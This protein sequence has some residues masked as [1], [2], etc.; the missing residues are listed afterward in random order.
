MVVFRVLLLC[1]FAIFPAIFAQIFE[2]AKI[3]IDTSTKIADTD[4]PYICATI[5]LWPPEKCNYNRCPW[6][7]SSALNLNLSHPFLNNAI[8]AF[9]KLRVRV[10][11]S[12]QDQVVYNVGELTSPCHPFKTQKG[13]LFGFSKGCLQMERW[14]ELN[15]FF[16]RTG[17]IVTFGLNALY[18]RHRIHNNKN[19]WGGTWDSSNAR[20]FITYTLSRGYH[21][22]SWEF[23]SVGAEQYG[24]DAIRLNDMLN[25][26][27]ANF[28]PKSAARL[29]APSG[30][31][32]KKWYGDLLK[33]SGPKAVDIL[34]YHLYTLG[35]GNDGNT[36]NKILN[37]DH[38]DEASRIFSMIT[39]TIQ[40]NGPWASAW[41]GESGG[42]FNNGIWIKL[43]WRL[44][45]KPKQTL[46][47]GFYGLLDKTTF[48][49]NPDYYSLLLTYRAC[50]A[51]IS[52]LLWHRLMGKAVLS[53]NS[54][55]SKYLR[56]YAHCAKERLSIA[57]LLI[58]LSNQT[59]Y[60]VEVQSDE[61]NQNRAKKRNSITDR[62]KKSVSWVGNKASDEKLYREEYHLTPENGNLTSQVMLLNGHPLKLTKNGGI[63]SLVPSLVKMG[64]ILTI[65][66]LSIKFVVYRNFWSPAFRPQLVEL[67]F[68]RLLLN[69][70]AMAFRILLLFCFAIFP[71][72][73]A[74][75]FEDGKIIIDTSAKIAETDDHYICATID[76]WPQEKCNYNKCPWGS[77]SAINLNLSHP[78]LNNAIRVSL[79]AFKNLR[80]RVGGSLQ[81]QVV[82]NVGKLT[83]PCHPFKQ[84]KGGLFGFSNGCLLM[85]RWDEL[86][87]FFKRT[88]VI[89]TFGLN[90]LYG[91]HR[92]RG[93][94]WGGSWY[95]RN[96]RDFIIYTLSKGYSIDY[97]EFGNELS[98]SGI[99][100][101][102]GA[103]QYG[104]DA[105]QLND[106]LNK[107][108]ADFS[109]KQVPCLITPSGFFD[110][111]WYGNGGHT[112]KN[113]LNPDHLDKTSLLFKTITSTIQSKGPW[114]SAWVGESGG[115]Y[116]NGAPNIS[117][118][119]LDSFWQT[120]IG[121]FYGLLDTT[122][123]VPNPDYYSA[124]L[125]HRLMGKAVLDVNINSTKYLRAYAHCAK[126][127]PG[128]A[129]LLIN[130][131]NQTTY[132]VDVQTDGKNQI[133]AEK[134]NSIT[135]KLKKS[136]SWVGENACEKKLYRAEYHLTPKNG[137]LTSRV[138][139]LN[140][141]PLKLTENGDI[142]S[143]VPSL[144]IMGSNLTIPPLSIKFV[145]GG[146]G[147]RR[148]ENERPFLGPKK[149]MD[150][151]WRG[152][153]ISLLEGKSQVKCRVLEQPT[154]G[155]LYMGGASESESSSDLSVILPRVVIV[156]RRC[157]R[158]NKFVDFVGEYHLDLI[159]KYGAVPVIVPRVSGVHT[160]VDSFGP[161]HGVLLCEGE[162]IDPSL[163][164]NN[165]NNSS[166]D[167]DANSHSLSPEEL[168]EI[169]LV[170][171]SDT[172]L[173]REKDAIE[174]ALAKL[175]L[176][177]NIP[178]L[179]ICRGSQLLNV[180]CGGVAHIDYQNYDAHR[181]PVRLVP[182]TPL[183]GWFGME[184]EI[185]VNS[186]H[187]QGV[188]RLAHRFVP[189]AFA[190]DGLVEAFYDPD[191]YCP[192]EGKLNT[193]TSIP[194]S[195][196]VPNPIRLDG[197]MEKKRKVIVRSFSLA[198]NI[199]QHP[200]TITSSKQSQLEAGAEFLE[201]NT[202]LSLQQETRLKQMGATVRNASSYL[203]RLR[204]KE[205]REKL[206]RNVMGNMTVEQLSDLMSF[207]NMMGQICSELIGHGIPD[208]TFVLFRD[209]IF[210]Q[211]SEEVKIIIDTSTKC[212]EAD[213]LYICATI[214]W[215]PQD[216]CN[217]NICPW[218]SSSAINLN[219]SHPFL[220]NL[221][222]ENHFS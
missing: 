222:W 76:W 172:A 54:N 219:L 7:S 108:Y 178:Y 44:S 18:G 211:I 88:G 80:L 16:N 210:A 115:A 131:S 98:G 136:V 45:F 24:K 140:G 46:I 36:V 9:K 2:D 39:S 156:S 137:D 176:E 174:L 173:D 215:W 111:K 132:I 167:G 126:E 153:S 1:C 58:N 89:V 146:K 192:N 97:W 34:S 144:V 66:P 217:Y 31:F 94:A 64:S 48:V 123:F 208:F 27:Y 71:A 116:N 15:K 139:L 55:S 70:S 218:G 53:V 127:S 100:A 106:M 105:V 158:K 191:A 190:P 38:L 112:M 129:V 20:D 183:H 12:L 209:A 194:T 124:L 85:N 109:R 35:P 78:F 161:I 213:D 143:L 159:V 74:Q 63:P 175:C 4:D 5:D 22:D 19:V 17:V 6:G 180:A 188:R 162:D 203:E 181:H 185:W 206:A 14:D 75:I 130:L 57:V 52:A 214:D 10:G 138:M 121:G 119:F 133:R 50:E 25:N 113:I 90:A 59:T 179:G 163:Y 168:D 68:F 23:A 201:S 197:E 216:K 207:Y 13:G 114:A 205:G 93:N 177:R 149:D 200:H 141:H 148:G 220:N 72:I 221:E 86:N 135:G 142:P 128:I 43:Q 95:S 171:A 151:L 186:Y 41:V 189:M 145:E 150:F 49:P 134:N 33:A 160:L 155:N 182:G 42:A 61:Q 184:E 29:I 147:Q 83:A 104:K 122:T 117:N 65:S 81:D 170:H 37:P 3:S 120:L 26:L 60:N 195:V 202:A 40:S 102:V 77:S 91:R 28:S 125:W 69:R 196:P 152:F 198:R 47:G 212:V 166:Q 21:I 118:T 187:H 103:E 79:T 169:R 30:F 199:Y 73:F 67:H 87:K 96:A 84:Q 204:V 193:S 101:S 107:L 32:D 154:Q 62:L 165:H 8:R 51:N 82:Y 11:G 92:I 164:N 110:K 56:A 157:V 99:G